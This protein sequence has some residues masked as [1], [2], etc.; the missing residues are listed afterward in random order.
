MKKTPKKPFAFTCECGKAMES[1]NMMAA[2]SVMRR[3][4]KKT[5]DGHVGS[6]R[7]KFT[8][9]DGRPVNIKNWRAGT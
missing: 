3:H 7:Y 8:R 1:V 9:V 2:L 4:R 5:H 6:L